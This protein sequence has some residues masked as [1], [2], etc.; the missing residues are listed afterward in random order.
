MWSLVA[1]LWRHYLSNMW[2]LCIC[3]A[4][5]YTGPKLQQRLETAIQVALTSYRSLKTHGAREQIAWL[6]LL[7]RGQNLAYLLPLTNWHRERSVSRIYLYK[8]TL[9]L[10]ALK[11]YKP[12]CRWQVKKLRRLFLS[13]LTLPERYFLNTFR[14]SVGNRKETGRTIFSTAC[15]IAKHLFPPK[16]EV[17]WNPLLLWDWISLCSASPEPNLCRLLH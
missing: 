15:N 10:L 2:L 5:G 1:D 16:W 17:L 4:E 7:A 6:T 14:S 11:S 8:A 13:K 12:L 3:T 9:F